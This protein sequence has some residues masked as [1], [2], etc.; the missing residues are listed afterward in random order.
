MTADFDTTDDLP[1]VLPR[2]TPLSDLYQKWS[3][4]HE[5]VERVWGL[6]EP[7]RHVLGEAHAQRLELRVND[8]RFALRALAETFG[9]DPNRQSREF[10][11]LAITVRALPTVIEQL[12]SRQA[13][14]RPPLARTAERKRLDRF[15]RGTRP[16][17]NVAQAGQRDPLLELQ[18][19]YRNAVDA[20]PFLAK[21]LWG[22]RVPSPQKVFILPHPSASKEYDF[23]G[24]LVKLLREKLDVLAKAHSSIGL[25][26]GPPPV[27]PGDQARGVA[28]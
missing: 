16:S 26:A 15:D 1:P 11:G 24:D 18:Y 17:P 23:E 3:E 9:L 20:V 4:Y 27:A 12:V 7:V 13:L 6:V 10:A 21:P 28:L 22:E 19:L 8:S 2:S 25:A 5:L 14:K